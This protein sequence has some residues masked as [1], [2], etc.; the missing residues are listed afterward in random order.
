MTSHDRGRG[1]AIATLTAVL[2]APSAPVF[3][4]RPPASL[5]LV[6]AVVILHSK[7]GQSVTQTITLDNLT[8]QGLAYE[9][10]AS[11]VIVTNGKRIFV[12]AGE[13]PN[14]IAASAVFSERSG[15]IQ[16]LS[17]KAVQVILTVPA[18]TSVRAVAVYFRSK[19]VVVSNGTVSL[20]ASVG[21]LVT[22][23]LTDNSELE[24]QPVHVRPATAS[25]NLKVSERLANIGTEP[26]VPDGVA[27]FIDTSGSIAARIP[28]VSQRLL[29][30]EHVEFSAEYSGRLKPGSY[31]VVCTFSY[32]GKALTRTGEYHA[33]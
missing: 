10:T 9:M 2:L 30:G 33:R 3:A 27:A 26:V 13:T 22:F 20:N 18:Q 28:F 31:R 32:A 24:A 23:V 21:S 4:Q 29:P 11:D 17:S 8:G 5:S 25:E 1:L 6:P 19:H 12:P 14:S 7:F 16:P 15:Y